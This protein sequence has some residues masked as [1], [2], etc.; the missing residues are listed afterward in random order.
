MPEAVVPHSCDALMGALEPNQAAST[1]PIRP[2]CWEAQ[3]NDAGPFS[4]FLGE[5]NAGTLGLVARDG[6]SCDKSDRSTAARLETY[7]PA[8]HSNLVRVMFNVLARRT[9]P[10]LGLR[11]PTGPCRSYQHF[12]KTTLQVESATTF[13]M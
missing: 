13:E 8:D 9:A 1:L 10:R 2:A 12:K 5:L 11:H 7:L 4:S 6:V 3:N